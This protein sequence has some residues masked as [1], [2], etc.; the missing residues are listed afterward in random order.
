MKIL[1][2][3]KAGDA[4]AR[5]AADY[6]RQRVDDLTIHELALGD[7]FPLTEADAAWDYVISYLCP[8]VVPRRVL[9]GARIAAINFH[10]GPPDYPG[11]GCTNFALYDGVA[12]FGV[13]CHHMA[14]RVDTGAPIAVVRF[15]VS[16]VDTVHSL[17]QRCYVHIAQLFYEITDL[18]LADKALPRCAE[19][20]TRPPILRAELDEL[21]RITPEL[22]AAEVERRVR[23]TTY[24]GQPG[25][26][27]DLA[28]Y[29]FRYVPD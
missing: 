28:G 8:L 29:R 24:P 2:L 23:A 18:I 5:N 16:D 10:P 14:P 9:D 25:P 19:S 27:V 15:P 3:A 13:T 17:T 1:F 26:F 20:W 7:R 22:S 21:C 6:L 4:F 12:S 11:I